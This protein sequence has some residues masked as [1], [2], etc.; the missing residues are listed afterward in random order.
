[1][2]EKDEKQKNAP[3]PQLPKGAQE[4]APGVYVMREVRSAFYAMGAKKP[5]KPDG[6]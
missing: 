1:M 4:I 3:K 2:A 6:R 5:A